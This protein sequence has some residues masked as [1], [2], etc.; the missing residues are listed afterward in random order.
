MFIEDPVERYMLARWCY[1]CGDPIISDVEY[2]KLEKWFKQ[3]YPTNSYATRSWSFDECPRHL[4]EKYHR[5]ELDIQLVMGYQAESISSLNTDFDVDRYFRDLSNEKTRVSFKIDGW[6]TRASYYNGVLVRFE[7]RGRSGTNLNIS[8]LS[9]FLPKRIPLMGRVAITGETS[10][11]NKLWPIYKGITGNTDQRASVRTA[12]SRGDI[13]YLSFLAFNIFSEKEYTEEFKGLD[14]YGILKRLG[15]RTP[16]Y[17]FVDSYKALRR[18]IDYMSLMSK[19]YGYLTDGLVVENDRLQL[20]LRVGAWL[21]KMNCSYVTEYIQNQG[22]YGVSFNVG[23]N[24]TNIGGKTIVQ[25]SVTNLAQIMDNRL[26]IGSP[27]AFSLRSSAN[28]VLDTENTYKL[29]QQWAGRYDEYR[30]YINNKVT[31]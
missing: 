1:L 7:T 21:E 12:L 27:I 14:S 28:V 23:V 15:F 25:V 4:L 26:E 18:C 13:G 29:Q 22:M 19:S 3:T 17:K 31:S 9:G 8:D 6:N 2:D 16:L 30:E 10:I 20:A 11:P 5:T 24:P